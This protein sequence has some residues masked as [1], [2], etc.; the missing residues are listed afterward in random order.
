MVDLRKTYNP[1]TWRHQFLQCRKKHK[2]TVRSPHHSLHPYFI[3]ATWTWRIEIEIISMLSVFRR[4][5]PVSARHLS[6]SLWWL[7]AQATDV[8]C[9]L[10]KNGMFVVFYKA[11]IVS[12]VSLYVHRVIVNCKRPATVRLTSACKFFFN[13]RLM[14]ASKVSIRS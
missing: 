6:N 13:I 7:T 9:S 10:V 11:T 5:V 8:R 3:T 2:L 14:V 4:L 1:S 12:M